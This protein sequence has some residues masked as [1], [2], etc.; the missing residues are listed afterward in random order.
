MTYW[1][2]LRR[3]A[4]RVKRTPYYETERVEVW[5][6]DTSEHGRCYVIEG[7]QKAQAFLA[8]YTSFA[9]VQRALHLPG[10][11]DHISCM[12]AQQGTIE[13]FDQDGPSMLEQEIAAQGEDPS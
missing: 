13:E 5:Y 7:R 10:P 2:R 6:D 3:S 12:I 1:E 11:I 4:R 8:A 9:E